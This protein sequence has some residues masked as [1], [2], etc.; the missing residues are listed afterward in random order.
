M[1]TVAV[2]IIV[3]FASV[4]WFSNRN[5]LLATHLEAAPQVVDTIA[6]DHPGAFFAKPATVNYFASAEVQSPVWF[7][8]E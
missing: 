6:N 7:I 2:T 8:G 5:I 1:K 4:L 3:I